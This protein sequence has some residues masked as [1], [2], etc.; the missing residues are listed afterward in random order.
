MAK[1]DILFPKICSLYGEVGSIKYFEKFFKGHELR[2]SSFDEE[3]F[4]VKEDVDFIY[5]GAMSEKWQIKIIEKLM[6]YKNRLKELIE[7]DCFFLT[8]ACGYEL[9]GKYIQDEKGNKIDAL[10]IF[11]YYAVQDFSARYNQKMLLEFNGERIVG[12]KSQ[13]SHVYGVSEKN[14][15]MK[16]K[17]GKGNNPETMLDG[18]KYK[19][20]HGTQ[21]IG[22]ILLCNTYLVDYIADKLGFDKNNIPLK[23]LIDEAY[24]ARLKYTEVVSEKDQRNE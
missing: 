10:G 13:F 8:V 23:S 15:W 16:A 18:F 21:V 5:L 3:P 1:I 2:F 24:Q 7:K 17:I 22:P 6:P 14:C 20:F 4:F 12:V 11:D 19:N 9:F